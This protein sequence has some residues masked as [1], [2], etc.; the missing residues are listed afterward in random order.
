MNEEAQASLHSSLIIPRSSFKEERDAHQQSNEDYGEA[1]EAAA[2]PV[3]EARARVAARDRRERHH[4]HV[5]PDDRA[6]GDEVDRCDAVDAD[7]EQVLERVHAVYVREAEEPER[8]QHQYPDPRAE[9]PAVHAHEELKDN[10][11]RPPRARR[12]GAFGP[13]E[14]ACDGLL[15]GEQHGREEY[16]EGD[17]ARERPGGRAQQQRGAEHPAR[18]R[19]RA[20]EQEESRAPFQLAPEAVDA[21]ERGGPERDRARRVRQHGVSARPKQRGERDERAPARD[22]V[23]EPRRERRRRDDQFLPQVHSRKPSTRPSRRTP[24][25]P[26][27][28]RNTARD[29][30]CKLAAVSSLRQLRSFKAEARAFACLCAA[31]F[32]LAFAS[33]ARAQAG[34]GRGVVVDQNG[35]PVAGAS[36]KIDARPSGAGLTKTDAE[37]RFDFQVGRPH[38]FALT[39]EAEGFGRFE[40]T[41]GRGEW[42]GG[43][44]RVVLAPP[45]LSERVTVTASRA[46]TRLGETAASVVVL[47]SDE[48]EATAALTP[49]DALR[50]V[51]G[52]QLFRRTG[53]RAANPTAQGASLRGVGASGASRAVVLYDGV[54]LN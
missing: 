12:L 36:V 41:W 4:E 50:Q 16:E 52:F 44:L 53:S 29:K 48:L 2:E 9:V 34:G 33:G 47:S 42:D 45:T 43:A 37:G 1:D 13:P 39:V 23:D 14:L 8:R 10:R 5:R 18:E 31:L 15:R 27:G 24:R 21:R 32:A 25:D 38:G 20:E 19:G 30:S 17:E 26:R 3:C 28:R 11:A 7:G 22:G 49:D 54:P 46:E 35:S 6:R 40:R 51:P